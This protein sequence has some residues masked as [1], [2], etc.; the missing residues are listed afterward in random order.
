M[1]L[2]YT[3]L[4]RLQPGLSFSLRE[5]PN[6]VLPHLPTLIFSPQLHMIEKQGTIE[7]SKK[8]MKEYVARRL[9]LSLGRKSLGPAQSVCLRE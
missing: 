1:A 3:I 7:R 9:Q 2:K 4:H 6:R 5:S 8:I